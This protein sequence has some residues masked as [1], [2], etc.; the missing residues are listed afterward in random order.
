MANPG[1]MCT[2][3]CVATVRR[4][5]GICTF[6]GRCF[7]VFADTRHRFF[8]REQFVLR[9][10]RLFYGEEKV[11]AFSVH[12]DIKLAMMH[13]AVCACDNYSPSNKAPRLWPRSSTKVPTGGVPHLR[14]LRWEERD[15]GERWLPPAGLVDK[16]FPATVCFSSCI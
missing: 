2:L 7:K 8:N 16:G 1:Q 3:V 5:C 11:F 6:K 15:R 12:P 10:I 13:L 9:R 14:E 4:L